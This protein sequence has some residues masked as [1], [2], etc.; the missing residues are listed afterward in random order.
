LGREAADE[1]GPVPVIPEDRAAFETAHHDMVEN[2]RRI[3]PWAAG[4]GCRIA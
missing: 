2:T 4:H 1:V 3:K